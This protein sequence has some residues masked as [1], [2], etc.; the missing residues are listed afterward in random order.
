MGEVRRM[1]AAF[2]A[3]LKQGSRAEEKSAGL[4]TV[5]PRSDL[6]ATSSYSEQP[7]PS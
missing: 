3:N 6:G 5:S 7:L 2:A 4:G 1:R